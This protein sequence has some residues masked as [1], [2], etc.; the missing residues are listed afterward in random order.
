MAAR[1]LDLPDLGL[2]IQADLPRDGQV[3]LHRSGRT[4]RAGRKG[5]C[6]LLA[7]YK[8][9]RGTQRMLENANIPVQ[10]FPPPSAEQVR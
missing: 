1:G 10:W 7:P 4:G 5:I 3:L 8:R 6:V 2:V 9:Q